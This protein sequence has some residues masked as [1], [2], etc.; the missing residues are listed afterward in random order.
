MENAQRHP[1]LY[2]PDGNLVVACPSDDGP[3][4]LFRIHQAFLS[5]HSSVIEDMLGLPQA[6]AANEMHDGA[7]VVRFNED[8]KDM[9]IFLSFFYQPLSVSSNKYLADTEPDVAFKLFGVFRLADML[10]IEPLK[11]KIIARVKQDWPTQLR[12]W[13][14]KRHHYTILNNN[15]NLTSRFPEPG[16]AI[17]LARVFGL[18]ML[19]PLMLYELSCR[20]PLA[21]YEERATPSIGIGARWELVSQED[22][23]NAERG[24]LNG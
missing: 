23:I 13:D 16:S 22:R 2:Y 15:Q 12:Q 11:E 19:S 14:D 20:D 9:E 4:T 6:D 24:R 10:M 21:S 5:S 17:R 1:T 7:P 3:A 18:G 8:P